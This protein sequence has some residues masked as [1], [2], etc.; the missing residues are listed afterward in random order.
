MKNERNQKGYVSLWNGYRCVEIA[1]Q[2]KLGTLDFM[3]SND[4]IYVIAG[5]TKPVKMSVTS[6][7]IQENSGYQ[8]HDMSMEYTYVFQAGVAV[9]L[10]K[11]IGKITLA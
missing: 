10:E 7:L 2:H 3:M 11:A 6:G 9:V 1:Q 8:N 4:E 5:D